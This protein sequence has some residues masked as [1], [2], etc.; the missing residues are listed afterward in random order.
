MIH[1][2]RLEKKIFFISDLHLP[3]RPSGIATPPWL[4]DKLLDWLDYIKPQAQAL[5]LLGDV[6]D[7]WFEYKHLVP[8]GAI[9]FQAKLWEFSKA[10]IPVYFF[11]GNHDGWSIDYLMQ[12][13]GVQLF[14][15]PASITIAGKRF[16]VGHGD[17]IHPSM[18][19]AL[20]RRLYHSRWLQ[21]FV[22]FLPPDWVY[23]QVAHYLAK[24]KYAKPSFFEE[25]DRIFRYCK[26]KIEPFN[27]HEFYIFGH[28]H[29]PYIK[30]FNHASSYC[31]L[32]AW[33]SHHTYACFDGTALSL[34]R[35]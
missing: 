22:R 24:K 27:H 17:T 29:C 1:I 19:Y 3:L 18:R 20:F 16:L 31:N 14:S 11:L 25:N 34:L 35:F 21:S 4:E 6:F 13:C 30:A 23:N 10:Q 5:F 9:R 8:R 15:A 28:T 32:S 2:T 7:F 33:I 26:D 12:E